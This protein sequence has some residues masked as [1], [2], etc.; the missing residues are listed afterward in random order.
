MRIP[1]ALLLGSSQLLGFVAAAGFSADDSPIYIQNTEFLANASNVVGLPWNTLSKALAKPD[2]RSGSLFTGFDWT[3][4]FPGS[5]AKDYGAYLSVVHDV[6]VPETVVQN[7]TTTVSSLTFSIPDS[8]MA[9]KGVTAAMHPSWY[10]CRHI[11][12][13]AANPKAQAAIAA[14]EGCGFLT[15]DC[16]KDLKSGLAS[17]WGTTDEDTMCSGLIFDAIPDSC[18]GSFGFAR[19]DVIGFDSTVMKDVNQAKL[20]AVDEQNQFNWR[21]G[22]GFHEKGDKSAYETA[23][24]RTYLVATVWGYSRDA[25]KGSIKT[26]EVSLA[27]LSSWGKLLPDPPGPSTTISTTATASSTQLSVFTAPTSTGT[28]LPSLDS[29]SDDFRDGTMDGW[30][31]YGTYDASSKALVAGISPG[32]MAL[33]NTGI[34]FA[35]F[36]F[37]ADI[38]IPAA[39]NGNAGLVFRATNPDN[40]ADSYS[41]YYAGI[42]TDGSVA[43]GRANGDWTHLGGA[44]AVVKP[45]QTYHMIVR[46]KGDSLAVYLDDMKTPKVDLKDG[47]YRRGLNG[48]RVYQTGAIF[49][50]INIAPV[51]PDPMIADISDGKLSRW[52]TYGG[53]FDAATKVLAAGSSIGGKAVLMYRMMVRA[54]G[55]KL[56]VYL[57]EFETPKISLQ[58]GTHSSGMVGVRV[59]QT[60]ATF[61]N[62]EITYL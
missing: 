10:I 6:P 51:K 59:L 41:G 43:L 48:V 53:N 23:Y 22:T 15:D 35:D 37:E 34:T 58:D 49:D 20:Q 28:T 3:K 9:S 11:Y 55:D 7:S 29:F 8:M 45:G 46:A 17:R 21:I 31:V 47:T 30:K 26:P 25:D 27:C 18:R 16:K 19:A 44:R 1:W 38:V 36:T 33:I 39:G 52:T 42:G 60:G 12:V 13:S 56:S 2:S 54:S 40:G 4:P 57:D 5:L 14:G 24:N 32:G 61:D 50:N 62:M